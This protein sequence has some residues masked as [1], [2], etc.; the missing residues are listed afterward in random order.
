MPMRVLFLRDLHG[1]LQIQV[2]LV[3]FRSKLS[4]LP[5]NSRTFSGFVHDHLVLVPA[6]QALPEPAWRLRT[7]SNT[8][9]RSRDSTPTSSYPTFCPLSPPHR[10]SFHGIGVEAPEWPGYCEPPG[11]DLAMNSV[12]LICPSFL[13]CSFAPE[14]SWSWRPQAGCTVLIQVLVL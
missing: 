1:H 10:F 12:S 13:F 4:S 8:M 9:R 3:V 11:S 7:N 6:F 5:P 14:Y 2:H